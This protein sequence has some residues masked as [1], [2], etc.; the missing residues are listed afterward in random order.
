M[1]EQACVHLYLS[2]SVEELAQVMTENVKLDNA[3]D[4]FAFQ[5]VFIPNAPLQKWLQLQIA[6][7][8]GALLNLN[9]SFL[10]QGLWDLLGELYNDSETVKMDQNRLQ[11][12]ILNFF[13]NADLSALPLLRR[14]FVEDSQVSSHKMWQLAG[15][16]SRL[17]LEYERNRP[18][19]IKSW[20]EG[21][22]YFEDANSQVLEQEQRLLYMS[23]FQNSND[24]QFKTLVQ[25]A[26]KLNWFKP[27]RKGEIPV[28]HVFGPSQLSV[29][30][31]RLLCKLGAFCKI[32]VYSLNV[33]AEYW[34]D[35]TS[36]GEDKWL[37][38]AL[39]APEVFVDVDGEEL[40]EI[41][42][43]SLLKS[44]GKPGRENLKIFSDLEEECL[45]NSVNFQSFWLPVTIQPQ[46][47]LQTVQYDILNRQSPEAWNE[48]NDRSLQIAACP[49]R[50]REVET[51]F[52]SIVHNMNED[53]DLKLT[54]IAVLVSDIDKYKAAISKV[55]DGALADNRKVITYSLIDTKAENVS[56][57]ANGLK[58]L[59]AILMGDFT[60]RN[61][62]QLFKN[63]CF[64]AKT[65]T[66]NKNAEI[67][68]DWC[69][70]L[71]MFREG[72][73]QSFSF[74][75]GIS[76]MR[77][78]RILGEGMECDDTYSSYVEDKELL[79][80][81]G[82]Y[83][84]LL[85][86]TANR[87][88]K[89]YWPASLWQKELLELM[90]SF[91]AI[92][93]VFPAELTIR[94]KLYEEVQNL[95]EFSAGHEQFL[96]NLDDIQ[97]FLNN[98]LKGI[99]V[100]RGMYLG[101]GITI[102][103][104]QPMRPVPFKHIYLLGLGENEF[105]GNVDK[106]TFDL[107]NY[108][109]K[110]GDISLPEKN[111][112]LFLETLVCA[113]EKLFLSYVSQDLKEDKVYKPSRL[114]EEL[115]NYSIKG[116]QNAER[117]QVAELPLKA[118]APESFTV[119][120]CSDGW[121]PVSEGDRELAHLLLESKYSPTQNP[122]LSIPVEVKSVATKDLALF[123]RNPLR[124]FMKN[125]CGIPSL[126]TDDSTLSED[127]PFSTDSWQRGDLVVEAVEKFAHEKF[128]SS[129]DLS[130]AG[131]LEELY[132]AYQK[133][134][135]LPQGIFGEMDQ[136][137]CLKEIDKLLNKLSLEDYLT[138]SA[139]EFGS[140]GDLVIGE[141]SW[142]ADKEVHYTDAVKV[143]LEGESYALR[144]TIENAIWSDDQQLRQI[145]SVKSQA[146][147]IDHI[148]INFINWCVL[149]S[150][151]K[152]ED[153]EFTIFNLKRMK[154]LR[155]AFSLVNAGWQS[156][157]ELQEWLTKLTAE[158]QSGEAL[159]LPINQYKNLASEDDPDL[160]SLIEKN[161]SLREQL[162]KVPEKLLSQS[163]D[164]IGILEILQPIVQLFEGKPK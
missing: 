6:D 70:T 37:Q 85:T 109:R 61:L 48:I 11:W 131:I 67:F 64:Q 1:E 135:S 49:G 146:P 36:P 114:I 148:L 118:Y 94:T 45:G 91:L 130:L 111:M 97:E 78:G 147:L 126:F 137:S 40:F 13:K 47:Y 120:A 65:A 27:Y 8:A 99:P 164:V 150:S 50:I 69:E 112:Y 125:N 23:L 28:I 103:S 123:L 143:E 35:I 43:N 113:R 14:Y 110:I 100:S 102:A 133:K 89:G 121:R 76:R 44:W 34:E 101:S 77:L 21:N 51:V 57:F 15:E 154:P 17:F 87:F 3:D 90:E 74:T 92:P 134:S 128:Y 39:K 159:F 139:S 96:F 58:Y 68:L 41:D 33:C 73:A 124:S 98:T 38:R 117:L 54:D 141:S 83:V 107:R 9:F 32:Y 56:H 93:D 7:K 62:L 95:V 152:C 106:S 22:F 86:D 151:G 145:F 2:N 160:Q 105:P 30:H 144:G 153:V 52:N 142:I 71:N 20:R 129:A 115:V 5:S 155:Y 24:S 157:E 72:D 82:F 156:K 31:K 104:L 18:D 53:V 79:S 162:L 25:H 161:Q 149:Y 10:E 63:P 138:Q 46:S 127:E 60:R 55:F 80:L 4:P 75:H 122:T 42:E 12:T 81:Y 136:Q 16:L 88:A 59:M 84:E 66:D 108:K 132:E 158:Y 140:W 29:F 163:A 119:N 116:K 19:M 26:T